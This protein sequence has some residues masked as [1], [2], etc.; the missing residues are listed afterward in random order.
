MDVAYGGFFWLIEIVSGNTM[1]N[2]SLLVT[3]GRA[4][5]EVAERSY[6]LRNEA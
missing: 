6:N 3:G 4:R 2:K 1:E 5:R